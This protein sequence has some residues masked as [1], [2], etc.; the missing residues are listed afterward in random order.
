MQQR[1]SLCIS[2][3]ADLNVMS[4]PWKKTESRSVMSDSLWP[5]GLQP[6]R[7]FCPWDSPGKNTG[8]GIY[9]LLWGIF[10]NQGL[11]LHLL[12]CSLSHKGPS[13]RLPETELLGKSA[14]SASGEVN[15]FHLFTTAD[16][17][18]FVLHI[19]PIE[20]YFIR[21]FLLVMKNWVSLSFL[22]SF[23]E[24]LNIYWPADTRPAWFWTL[25]MQQWTKW[26]HSRGGGEGRESKQVN[27]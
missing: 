5:H 11:N 2:F 17:V 7:L 20:C 8:V 16:M 21:V 14:K 25:E 4:F 13:H 1:K 10:P 19:L 27:K 15:N 24:S 18:E 6:T 23:T 26:A 9:S 12:H 22:Y 3:P